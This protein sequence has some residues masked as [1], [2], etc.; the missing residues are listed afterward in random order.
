MQTKRRS[1]LKAGA[2]TL[3]YWRDRFG[4]IGRP[5]ARVAACASA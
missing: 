2:P 4:L 5:A 1:F 3:D